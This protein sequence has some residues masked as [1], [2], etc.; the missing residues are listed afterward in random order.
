MSGQS[1]VR[2]C[3]EYVNMM[4]SNMYLVGCS[5]NTSC[6]SKPL[7]ICVYDPFTAPV[8]LYQVG[9]T[10]TGCPSGTKKIGSLCA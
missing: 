3:P 10:V 2:L 4:I 7:H 8:G 9:P 5:Y 6:G 1:G